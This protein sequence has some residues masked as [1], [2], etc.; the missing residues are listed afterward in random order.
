MLI[1]TG[2]S[3]EMSGPIGGMPGPA[4]LVQREAAKTLHRNTFLVEPN[5]KILDWQF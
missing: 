4:V 1:F 5:W 3:V 2:L